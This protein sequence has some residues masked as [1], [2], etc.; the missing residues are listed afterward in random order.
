MRGTAGT[1][2]S[3]FPNSDRHIRQQGYERM[4]GH[5]LPGSFCQWMVSLVSSVRVGVLCMSDS[6]AVS[7]RSILHTNPVLHHSLLT[8]RTSNMLFISLSLLFLHFA[9]GCLRSEQ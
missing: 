1:A 3:A 4:N 6:L 9:G 2:V 5:E 8:Y 7:E